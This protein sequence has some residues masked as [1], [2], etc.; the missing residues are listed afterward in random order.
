MNRLV[1]D[2]NVILSGFLWK[3]KPREILK[4]IETKTDAL[5][6]SRDLLDELERVLTY[7]KI[8]KILK[9]SSV[10]SRDLLEWVIINSSLVVVRPLEKIII[11]EDPSDDIV[12]SCAV[13]AHA[14]AIISG[15]KHILQLN[16]YENIPILTVSDYVKFLP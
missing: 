11:K 14:D 2:T 8:L 15:D 13:T 1:C 10:T 9:Q 7:S 3:G 16:K 4:R 12:L 6:V 5:F